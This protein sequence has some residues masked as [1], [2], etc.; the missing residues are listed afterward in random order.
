MA[1]SPMQT[2]IVSGTV[3]ALAAAIS[4][5]SG[6]FWK[7]AF[8]QWNNEKAAAQ[9]T[10][11]STPA[12]ISAHKSPPAEPNHPPVVAH[13][14][15]PHGAPPVLH[16]DKVESNGQTGGV[17]TGYVGTINQTNTGHEQ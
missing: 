12:M 7:R 6:G 1:M 15:Q 10:V 3:C 11:V 2:M 14:P 4:L 9:Q 8:D 13:A 5:V 16:V 17:T